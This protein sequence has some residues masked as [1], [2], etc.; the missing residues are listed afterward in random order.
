ML[1]FPSIEEPENKGEGPSRISKGSSS[2]SVTDKLSE[3]PQQ[4]APGSKL[5]RFSPPPASPRQQ[6]L[7]FDGNLLNFPT[8][9]MSDFEISPLHK[10]KDKFGSHPSRGTPVVSASEG[11][12]PSR[13]RASG[14]NERSKST[15]RSGRTLFGHHLRVGSDPHLPS[16]SFQSPTGATDGDVSSSNRHRDLGSQ[17]PSNSRSRGVSPLRFIQNFSSS[18][19]HTRHHTEP[20][21]PFVPVNPFKSRI[22]FEFTAWFRAQPTTKAP[23]VEMAQAS[24]NS[25]ST[26]SSGA[27]G[28]DVVLVSSVRDCARH[29]HIFIGDVLP[30][31]IYLNLLL[32]LPALYFS[33]V[34]RVFR[35]AEVSR[36]DIERM[37]EAG[38]F[39][40]LP[41][42]YDPQLDERIL[43]ALHQHPPRQ[44]PHNPVDYGRQRGR[45]NEMPFAHRQGGKSQ[46]GHQ[47]PSAPPIVT[48]TLRR[49]QHSWEMFIDSLLREWKT[50]NVVSALLA[51]AILTIFQIPDAAGDP[52]TRTA[53]ILSLI[54]SL[55]SLTYGCMYIVR[56]STMRT[57]IRASKWAEEA[58]R[59]NT[60]ILWNVW[61][62]LAMPAVWLAWSMVIFMVAILS[63]VWRTGSEADPPNGRPPL[64]T[65]AAL[66]PRIAITFLSFIGLVYLVLIVRTLKSYGMHGGTSG[67]IL[68]SPQTRLGV[69]GRP[70]TPA[71]GESGGLSHSALMEAAL[72]RRGRERTRSTGMRSVRRR[73]EE[74]EVRENREEYRGPIRGGIW[75]ENEL[76]L[77][78]TRSD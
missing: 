63:F 51:S 59:T 14:E 35:D 72:E 57:M 49:F 21:E 44:V 6:R 2:T 42:P 36:P 55:M 64:S 11:N 77:Y 17:S 61:V 18:F 12:S 7:S 32:R 54:C 22:N 10:L 1:P 20:E 75:E 68:T 39:V 29:A 69:L 41:P 37:I 73:E 40:I 5:T 65:T 24:V 46:Q 34:A 47:E 30:R 60:A 71:N 74:P 19:H 78:P 43:N 38:E 8:L 16:S 50:L 45:G 13:G 56:F 70:N 15:P 33:R 58:R 66:G 27:E 4:S 28:C 52:I 67:N 62:L 31:L 76:G 26:Q 23:D 9:H 53:A 25:S 3:L 48:P